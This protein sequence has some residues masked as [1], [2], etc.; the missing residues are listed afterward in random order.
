MP[1]T[2]SE[3]QNS[4]HLSRRRGKGDGSFRDDLVDKGV[5]LIEEVGENFLEDV[6]WP[7]V[8]LSSDNN[9]NKIRLLINSPGGFI[10]EMFQLISM[11]RNSQKPVIAEVLR[12]FSAGFIIASQCHERVAYQG[13]Q[14]MYHI[15][16]TSV[17]G[18]QEEIT[19]QTKYLR[20]MTEYSE[21]LVQERTKISDAKILEYR[22]KDWYMTAKEA[23]RW[24]VIDRIHEEDEYILD[25]EFV[26]K[27]IKAENKAMAKLEQ[28]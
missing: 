10:T 18:N 20:R 7:F 19:E 22:T 24:G 1:E 11:I 17:W 13:S 6:I 15:P 9:V 28:E 21:N 25:P 14:F 2:T 3:N 27:R 4:K 26:Q 16:W 23:L 5:I 12:A 8:K